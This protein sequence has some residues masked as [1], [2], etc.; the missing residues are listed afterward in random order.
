MNTGKHEKEI[1]VIKV[2]QYGRFKVT[3]SQVKMSNEDREIEN[4]RIRKQFMC[5]RS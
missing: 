3:V 5:T 4:S 2:C 1:E